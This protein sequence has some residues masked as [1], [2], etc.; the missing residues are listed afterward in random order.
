[1]SELHTV[2]TLTVLAALLAGCSSTTSDQPA[3]IPPSA[4]AT[5][6]SS[7]NVSVTPTPTGSASAAPSSRPGLPVPGPATTATASAADTPAGVSATEPPGASEGPAIDAPAVSAVVVTPDPQWD[8]VRV[9]VA[10]GASFTITVGADLEPRTY[11]V[12]TS[13]V[14]VAPGPERE[15]TKRFAMIEVVAA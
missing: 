3:A 4:T 6:A 10:Q 11:A 14:D 13:V 8:A 7:A 9:T 15:A 1:V 2:L 12:L 5:A